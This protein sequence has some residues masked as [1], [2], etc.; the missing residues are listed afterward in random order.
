MG[1][2][3]DPLEPVDVR[4]RG[5]QSG[6]QKLPRSGD[7]SADDEAGRGKALQPGPADLAESVRELGERGDRALVA[8]S[9]ADRDLGHVEPRLAVAL[10]E[11]G[12]GHGSLDRR[13]A[14]LE[15]MK[16]S[17]RRDVRPRVDDRAVGEEGASETRPERDADDAARASRCAGPP[18]AED[19]RVGVVHEDDR[20]GIELE[21]RGQRPAQVDAVQPYELVLDPRDPRGVVERPGDG[22]A[23]GVDVRCDVRDDLGHAEEDLVSVGRIAQRD[24]RPLLDRSPLDVDDTGADVRPAEIERCDSRAHG[25]NAL[26]TLQLGPRSRWIAYRP[27]P[28]GTTIV[29]A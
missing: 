20:A 28:A 27:T 2:A 19:E 16:L 8:A 6:G 11:R 10:D 21:R 4:E 25:T 17:C 12:A 14:E 23:H 15:A 26:T 1:C 7:R 13:A 5:V 3:H 9:G 29:S 18:L 24:P 22:D